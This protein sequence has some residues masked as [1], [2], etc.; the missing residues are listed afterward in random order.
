M[1]SQ[2]CPRI[3]NMKVLALLGFLSLVITFITV[4]YAGDQQSGV[5]NDFLVH[6]SGHVKGVINMR[7]QNARPSHYMCKDGQEMDTRPLLSVP[8]VGKYCNIPNS[9]PPGEEG[10]VSKDYKLLAAHVV[11]RHGDRAPLI[12][13]PNEKAPP[14]SCL[15]DMSQFKHVPKMQNY[16]HVMAQA[17]QTTENDSD[18]VAE[19]RRW[20]M[21]PSRTECGE[22]Q[23]T[24]RGATQQILSGLHLHQRY[25][26]S[27]HNLSLN[28]NTVVAHT[29]VVSRTYQSAVAFLYGLLT[30]FNPKKLRLHGAS[31]IMFCDSNAAPGSV[32]SCPGLEAF[33]NRAISKCKSDSHVFQSLAR[34]E[35]T[36]AKTVAQVLGV[37][38]VKLPTPE[39]VMDALSRYACHSIP[40]PCVTTTTNT[41]DG[42]CSSVTCINA[43][44]MEAVWA[45]VDAMS[46]CISSNP[47]YRKY[48][49]ASTQGLLLRIVQG[50]HRATL[51]RKN[52]E[53]NT[54][55]ENGSDTSQK[56]EPVFVLY[57]GHDNTLT[58]LIAALGLTDTVW[59]GYATRLVFEL[60]RRKWSSSGKAQHFV[61][62]LLNG[63]PV[64]YE[65]VFCKAGSVLSGAN[66]LCEFERFQAHIV[67]MKVQSFCSSLR[68]VSNSLNRRRKRAQK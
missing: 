51:R 53:K 38:D 40:P 11:I 64:T 36:A 37:P 21:Y 43:K 66:D 18:S 1:H 20:A 57:S 60:Y 15:V 7:R 22:G 48:S 14:L 55:T 33:R 46:S 47:D 39:G 16:Q 32:C 65:T 10:M 45:P 56:H 62:V 17:A 54:G 50:L 19:F 29:T 68:F 13:L 26:Q 34:Y 30:D 9:E 35:E 67:G 63:K 42:V 52:N 28:L 58:P 31:S 61:R 41:S 4:R 5:E 24:G 2:K 44:T 23:L 3:L 12:H 49:A 27:P 25:A 6:R 59:P 8:R